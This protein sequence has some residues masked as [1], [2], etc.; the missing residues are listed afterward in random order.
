MKCRGHIR[1]MDGLSALGLLLIVAAMLAMVT[2]CRP[3]VPPVPVPPDADAAPIEP[4]QPGDCE[5]ACARLREL[6]CPW[7][8]TTPGPDGQLG[9]PDDGTCEAVCAEAE[10]EPETTLNPACVSKAASC[11][12]AEGCTR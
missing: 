12:A 1:Q 7:A 4:T 8:E 9:T 3:I 10:R 2:R 11:A 6:A 5:R